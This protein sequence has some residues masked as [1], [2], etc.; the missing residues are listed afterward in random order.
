M[1]DPSPPEAGKTPICGIIS[2]FGL[3]ILDE[4]G[5]L[6]RVA[7]VQYFMCVWKL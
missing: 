3:N 5:F 2:D 6:R 7:I 1:L 4:V